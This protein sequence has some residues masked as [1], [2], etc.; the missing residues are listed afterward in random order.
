MFLSLII[1]AILGLGLYLAVKNFTG[2]D[3]LKISPESLIKTIMSSDTVY[4]GVT[5][6]LSVGPPGSFKNIK[7]QIK[8]GMDKNSNQKTNPST[9]DKSPKPTAPLAYKFAIVGDSHK[10]MEDLDKALKQAKAADVKFV[11]GVGDFSDVGTIEEL[12]NTKQQFDSSGLTYYTT[13]GDHDLWDSTNKKQS[14][15]HNFVAVFGT[16]YQS[17]AYQ[18]TR[19][20]LM[21]DANDYDG[22]DGVQMSWLQDE[23]S[24]TQDSKPKTLFVI[25]DT[26]I[27]H[28][29]SDH[30]M[31]RVTPKLKDQAKSLIDLFSKYKVNEVFAADT[32]FYTSYVEPTHNLNMTTIGAVTSNPNAQTPR[33]VI[34]DIYEDGSYNI[35]ETEIH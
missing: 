31:G 19:F 10:D 9:T 32:H 13:P 22:V 6:L 2:Y 21:Y 12:Q 11:I 18:D 33:F 5:G 30:S 27:Y 7:N 4:K 26:P 29:S 25:T 3:P 14:S 20:I 1:M 8:G 24:R 23:L 35:E 16:P 34:V 28:P 17:F 15:D